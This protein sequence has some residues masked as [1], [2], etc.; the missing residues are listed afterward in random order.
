MS[1]ERVT[2][3][4]YC[5]TRWSRSVTNLRNGDARTP[6]LTL[7]FPLPGLML[8][9]LLEGIGHNL[10]LLSRLDSFALSLSLSRLHL[11]RR[12]QNPIR[13]FCLPFLLS[14]DTFTTNAE[15]CTDR[16]LHVL[17]RELTDF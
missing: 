14:Q 9:G 4:S 1:Q 5:I 16:F 15:R 12:V 10:S 8:T 13:T 6:F 3:C 17:V 11:V 2:R 7:S